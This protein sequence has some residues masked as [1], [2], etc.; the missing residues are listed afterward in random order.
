M[1]KQDQGKM[2]HEENAEPSDV[3]TIDGL[4]KALYESVT[5]VSGRQPDFTRFR[6]LFRPRALVIPHRTDKT[7]GVEVVD[8]ELYVKNSVEK[9][10]L[11][12]MERKGNVITEIARR[13]LSFGNIV[14]VF[15]TF[16]SKTKRDDPAPIERGIYSIQILRASHRWWIVSLMWEME[17][18]DLPLPRAYLI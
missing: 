17:R 3:S 5:F 18:P 14:H 6:S 9:I 8:V 11:T 12:G 2:M 7:A 10:V 13:T 1:A 15:S 16:E 4:I